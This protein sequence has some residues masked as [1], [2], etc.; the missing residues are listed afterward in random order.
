MERANEQEGPVGEREFEV[1][2]DDSY[3]PYVL[4]LYREE[5]EPPVYVIKDP[6]EQNRVEFSSYSYEEACSWLC[7]DEYSRIT[8]RMKILEWWEQES[9]R[10]REI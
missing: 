8:G 7:E 9:Y 4:L 6:K 5:K 3:P 2:T 1:W 10:K